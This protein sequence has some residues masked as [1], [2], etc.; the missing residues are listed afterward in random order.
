MITNEKI[1]ERMKSYV[2]KYGVSY[3]AIGR[4]AG[5]GSPSRYLVSRFMRGTNLNHDTLSKLDT[6]LSIRG[7]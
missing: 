5:L 7:F 1:R 4:E 6:Y 3:M 2:D